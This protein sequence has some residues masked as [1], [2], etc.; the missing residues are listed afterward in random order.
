MGLWSKGLER[1]QMGVKRLED[2]YV[3]IEKM[4]IICDFLNN[5]CGGKICSYKFT[6]PDTMVWTIYGIS[7]PEFRFGSVVISNERDIFDRLQNQLY[8][9]SC[10]GRYLRSERNMFKM[11][12]T[13]FD[14][15]HV[16]C[17]GHPERIFEIMS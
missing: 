14:R 16:A 12:L 7:L 4:E 17:D 13:Q 6:T 15:A 10:S 11:V 2:G 1:A 9:A 5:T 8:L 3:D